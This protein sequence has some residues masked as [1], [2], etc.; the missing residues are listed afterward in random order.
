MIVKNEQDILARCLD[1]VKSF[2]DEIIIVDTGSTDN[3]KNI[4]RQY[5]DKVFDF[6]WC[7]DFS[8]ARNFSFSKATGDYIIWL[9][10]DDVIPKEEQ[11][12]IL[13]LKLKLN[14][15]YLPNIIM[16]YYVASV[17]NAGKPNFY[18]YRER[19][20]KNGV[21]FIWQEP[22]HECITPFGEIEYC[23]IKIYHKKIRASNPK[24][25]LKIYQKLE[26]E[27]YNFSPRALYYFGRELSFNNYNK[28]SNK[29]LEKF[30]KTDGW[31]E[32]K[33][34][35][36]SIIAGNY[37]KLGDIENAKKSLLNSF[38]FDKP[39]SKLC[40]EL[41]SIF[42]NTQDY[43][44]AKFWYKLALNAKNSNLGWIENDYNTFIP[45]IEL[46]VCC[47][48]LG[49]KEA[50]KHYHELSK[51]YAPNSPAVIYNNKFF[52]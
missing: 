38:V 4:A 29:I 30:L 41:A 44:T 37:L 11:E 43:E 15:N 22:V 9:D 36:C 21:G 34:D 5:T 14:E 1:C 42:K 33:I 46:C 27:K 28:K 32:N 35:A 2:A 17:D 25:N 12:K 7:D 48:Q 51:R 3:T 19:I 40:C 45:A 6:E 31:I 39:R 10:A 47:F 16:C 52:N 26:K 18:Y 23:N 13:A 24:R 8:K 49:E 20:I 50:A